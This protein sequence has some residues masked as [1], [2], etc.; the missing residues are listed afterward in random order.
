[1]EIDV[2]VKRDFQFLIQIKAIWSTRRT[3]A[4]MVDSLTF[5]VGSVALLAAP[6]ACHSET[7]PFLFS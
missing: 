3:L 6:V 7:M 4:I 2:A 1:V 5:L